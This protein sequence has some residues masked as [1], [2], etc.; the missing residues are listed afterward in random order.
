MLGKLLRYEFKALL[1]IM[2]VLYLVLQVLAVAAGVNSLIDNGR[3]FNF[4]TPAMAGRGTLTQVLYTIWP[5]MFFALLTVNL[6]LVI[7]RFRD[8][9]LKDEGYLMFTLPVPE[10]ALAASKAIAAL[11]TFLLTAIAGV[12][13]LL[14]FTLIAD[15]RNLVES[16]PWM[17]R[18]WT[19][20]NSAGFATLSLGAVIMLVVVFQQLCLIY[21]AMT[22]SQLVPR[23][24]GFAGFGAYLAVMSIL[25]QPLTKAVLSLP[26]T[27]IPHLLIIALTQAAFAA[28]YLWCTSTLLKYTFN[29]E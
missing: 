25:E 26:L 6:A 11:C 5:M 17:F 28:L 1:Q 13:S 7:L 8:N 14:I 21:A 3:D 19:D 29:L 15:F 2:P 24:R 23:F 20:W 9:F 18:H 10:W 22:V 4:E 12:L 16:L 27:G